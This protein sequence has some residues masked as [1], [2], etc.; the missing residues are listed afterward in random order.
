MTTD[1]NCDMGEGVG[2]DEQLMP[3]ISSVNIACGKHA[4]DATTMRETILLAQ[5]QGIK[6]GAHPSFDDKKNF[7]RAEMNL[8]E[9]EL[10]NLVFSQMEELQ[11]ICQSVGAQL[12]HVKPH[13]ALYNLSAHDARTA[14]LIARAVKNFNSDLILFGLSG[15]HSISEAKL[16]GLKTASE[17]FADRTYQDDG[18]LTPRKEV[19]ALIESDTQALTQ[20]LEMIEYGILTT[21]TNKKIKLQADTVCIHGDGAHA[22]TFAKKIF[23]SFKAKGIEIKSV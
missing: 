1:I 20:V 19:N 18:S 5:K 10:Y 14:A 12:H 4:G 8:P 7:G 2:N 22:V 15:S 17:V 16:I 6:I 13:G 3:F 23:E 9:T 21:V 11:N